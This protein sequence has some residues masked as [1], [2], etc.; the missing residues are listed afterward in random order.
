MDQI[1]LCRCFL[2]TNMPVEDEKNITKYCLAYKGYFYDLQT[3]HQYEPYDEGKKEN[4]Y[5]VMLAQMLNEN[6]LAEDVRDVLQRRKQ[7]LLN[8]ENKKYTCEE[9]VFKNEDKAFPVIYYLNKITESFELELIEEPKVGIMMGDN[10]YDLQTRELISPLGDDNI[11]IN[12]EYLAYVKK[13]PDALL[14]DE[15]KLQIALIVSELMLE[16]K[17]RSSKI[18][19]LG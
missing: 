8:R 16:N 14:N 2:Q 15:E 4:D 12:G 5:M 10:V 7:D 17:K 6:Y 9:D 13:V 19:V 18:I 1:K 3:L 11:D